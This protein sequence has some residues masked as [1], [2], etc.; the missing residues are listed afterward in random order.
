[1]SIRRLLT[2]FAVV[3]LAIA[4]PAVATVKDTVK[5]TFNVSPGGTLKIDSDVGS[6]EVQSGSG[7]TVDFT[8]YREASSGD[9]MK[10][11]KLD[12]SQSGSNVTLHA[13]Y[14]HADSIFNL[15]G[16][17]SKLKLRFVVTVPKQ[18][19]AD[20]E[21]GGGSV[22]VADLK[23]E[24]RTQTSGGSLELGS[25]DGKVWG[26]TSGGLITLEKSSGP[27]DIE[28]S[29][30]AIKIS[31][32][33]GTVNAETSGGSISIR[34]ALGQVRAETSGGAIRVEE[35]AGPI[36]AH[37]SG[38]PIEA[39]I[40]TQPAGDCRLSTSGGGVTVFLPAN[41]NLNLDAETS[42][43][44]VSC[45]LP[46][47]TTGMKDRSTLKGTINGGGPRLVLRSSGGGIT[48]NKL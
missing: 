25:I 14:K 17:G 34:R 16:D 1:M 3:V 42:S 20:L 29:G 33:S 38:G 15:F 18:F 44:G 32:V 4:L 43:G 6:I 37:T 47:T 13:E 36:H 40:T 7:N 22:R 2:L 5:R 27:A 35:V 21:T 46:V 10:K 26:R 28:T 8:I 48:I 23:G 30:G 19:N 39:R 41:V 45:E 9:E 11:L 12:F 24:V 31:E